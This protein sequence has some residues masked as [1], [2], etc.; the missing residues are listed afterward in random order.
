MR[1]EVS[2]HGMERQ[3][4]H[5]L[6]VAVEHNDLKRDLGTAQGLGSRLPRMLRHHVGGAPMAEYASTAAGQSV[7]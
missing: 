2:G 3:A 1:T 5:E 7:G 6:S 4:A